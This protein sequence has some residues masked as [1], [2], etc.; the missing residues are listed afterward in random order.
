MDF[1][2][3]VLSITRKNILGTIK[4]LSLEQ[5]NTIPN[6]F[7]N[8]IAW[9]IA[10]LVVT[11]Q[12]LHY[13]LS[14]NTPVISKDLI[15]NFKKGTNGKAS[16]SAKEWQEVKDLFATLPKLLKRDF[17]NKLFCNFNEYPTSYNVILTSIEEAIIFNNTHEAMH[18][19]TI[20][21]M[22]KQL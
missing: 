13:K 20:A 17:E 4:N 19:G 2:F 7:N 3:S 21:A 5:L 12:L 22:L 16:L 15:E 11:Q 14:G 9:Q 8:S 10:H 1:H 18:F 6:K